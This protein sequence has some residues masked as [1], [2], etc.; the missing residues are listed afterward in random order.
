MARTSAVDGMPQ[1][2]PLSAQL[3]ASDTL[4]FKLPLELQHLIC[5]ESVIEDVRNLRL[6]CKTLAKIGESHFTRGVE[7]LFTRSSFNRFNNISLKYGVHVKS[8]FY[9]V[10]SLTEHHN[11]EGYLDHIVRTLAREKDDDDPEPLANASR[12]ELRLYRRQLQRSSDPTVQ[13]SKRQLQLGWEAY[14]KLWDEQA[15]LRNNSYGEKEI[16]DTISRLPNLEHVT[17]LNFSCIGIP[18]QYLS[19]TYRKTLISAEGD[20]GYGEPCGLPQLLSLVRAIHAA[21]IT[22]ENLGVGA[23]SW[24]IF[25]VDGADREVL[26]R[27]FA[28]LKSFE[29]TFLKH[30]FYEGNSVSNPNNEVDEEDLCK[31]FFNQGGHLWLLRS[32]LSLR[33]LDI[34]PLT[35]DPL[36]LEPMA[37]AISWHHLR[38]VSLSHVESTGEDLMDFLRR[39]SE[40]LRTLKLYRC[41]LTKGLWLYLFREMRASLALTCLV[42]GGGKSKEHGSRD[43][44][45]FPDL[46]SLDTIHSY[47]LRS[48]LVALEDIINHG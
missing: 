21:G 26:T 14:K 6:T 48:D 40:T 15:H 38:N 3:P 4:I 30:Q 25:S 11:F 17:L 7:L 45:N 41:W 23:I 13:Y 28:S 9:R 31:K 37:R 16:T 29:L 46:D 24:K 10:D 19:D 8:L 36:P 44:W 1:R 18:T 12:R 20:E 35:Y 43:T 47:L 5:A 39:H 33:R 2:R 42:F 27:V 32:M 34:C 22:I